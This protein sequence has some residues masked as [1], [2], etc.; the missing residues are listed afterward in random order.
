MR[1][2]ALVALSVAGVVTMIVVVAATAGQDTTPEGGY[3]RGLRGGSVPATISDLVRAAGTTCPAP[4][5]SVLAAQLQAESSWNPLARSGAGAEG[6][7]QFMPA[8]WRQWGRDGNGDGVAS[9]WNPADA[10]ASQAAYDCALAAQMQEALRAGRVA[11]PVT[12]LMLAAYNAGPQA[13]LAA[14]GVPPIKETRDYVARITGQAAGFADSTGPLPTPG[15]FA[16]RLVQAA[17]S[18]IGVPY[19]WGGGVDAG[20]SEGFGAGRGT[21]GYDCSGLVLYAVFQASGGTI[22]LPHSADLQTRPGTG[23]T[24]VPIGQLQA[25]D[26]IS[27]TRPGDAAAHH[28]GIYLGAGLMVDAPQTGSQVRIDS[29]RSPYWEGQLWRA[30]R[31]SA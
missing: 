21:V 22:R 13:V 30:V 25:G 9:P 3:G 5:A 8:T 17:R 20:P 27:F 23:G 28:V 31:Y 14:G 16:S 18:Q 12:D 19:A 24:G 29:L 7:A 10:I 1:K 6:I 2:P 4:P 15:S 26:V 11:G